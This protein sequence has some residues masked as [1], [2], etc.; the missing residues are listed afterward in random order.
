MDVPAGGESDEEGF[1]RLIEAGADGMLVVALDGTIELANPSACA[2]LGRAE[3]DLVGRPFGTPLVPGETTEIDVHRPD[4]QARVA[5]MRTA[6]TSWMDR[7]AHLASLRD[8]TAR[9]RA[10]EALKE[11]DRRKDEFLAMLA[12]EL[13]NPLAAINNAVNLADRSPSEADQAWARG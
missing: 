3:R 13:R 1:R 4:G 2:L 9:K 10:E 6:S 12:H 5:E 11:A 8:I 7:P